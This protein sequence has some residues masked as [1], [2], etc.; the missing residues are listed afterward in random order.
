MEARPESLCLRDA[1]IVEAVLG[2]DADSK[3]LRAHIGT[4][5]APAPKSSST[6]AELVHAFVVAHR[7]RAA[8]RQCARL[9]GGPQEGARRVVSPQ[10]R[11]KSHH[12]QACSA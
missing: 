4:L 11:G 8:D 5:G 1:T 7:V 9:G 12:F 10:R 3:S 6:H 2:K